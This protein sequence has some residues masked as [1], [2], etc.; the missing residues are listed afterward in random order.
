MRQRRWLELVNNYDCDIS[1]DPGKANVVADA[2]NRKSS[3]SLTALLWLEKSLQEDFCILGIEL[4]T[5][6]LSTMTIESTLLE[7]I[8]QCQKEDP[9]LIW[10]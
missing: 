7:K 4:I 8:K 10:T 1:Y 5:G 9:E 2:L 3:G 6:R